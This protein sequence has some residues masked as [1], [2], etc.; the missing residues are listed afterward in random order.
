M[1][2][3]ARSSL[4]HPLFLLFS[5]S[6]SLVT[7]VGVSDSSNCGDLMSRRDGTSGVVV[8]EQVLEEEIHKCNSHSPLFRSLLSRPR[9]LGEIFQG[10]EELALPGAIIAASSSGN[11]P[12]V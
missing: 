11:L 9:P 4:F 8:Y 5:L 12:T 10:S 2:W 6:L 3:R 7:F 1:Q